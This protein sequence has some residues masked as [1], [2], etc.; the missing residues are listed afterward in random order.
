MVGQRIKVVLSLGS[1]SGDRLKAVNEASVWL[2]G[3][4]LDFQC[5][6]VYE[7]PPLGHSGADY[8]NAVC[9]G[10]YCGDVAEL[11]R[12]CKEY[13]RRNGRDEVARAMNLVPIDVDIVISDGEILR[14]KD[15]R[16]KFFQIGYEQL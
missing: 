11:E 10:L 16:S 5:S 1:N 7:T 12:E 4:L 8:M 3:I 14:P 6:A 9:A 15:Y 2:K 13:E